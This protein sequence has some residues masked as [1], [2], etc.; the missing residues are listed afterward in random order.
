M[1][2]KEMNKDSEYHTF[3]FGMLLLLLKYM[4][5]IILLAFPIGVVG[6]VRWVVL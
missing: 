1:T 2:V 4:G 5:S 3:E 6:E